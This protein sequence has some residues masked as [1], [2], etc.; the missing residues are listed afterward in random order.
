VTTSD[1]RELLDRID[2][3]DAGIKAGLSPHRAHQLSDL[4]NEAF[5][6]ALD[7]HLRK[8]DS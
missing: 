2:R 1:L 3:F 5:N 8:C 4:S 7:A 6:R